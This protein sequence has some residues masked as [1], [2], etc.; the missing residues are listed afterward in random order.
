MPTAKKQDVTEDPPELKSGSEMPI[1]GS[2]INTN[3]YIDAASDIAISTM[4]VFLK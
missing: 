4:S 2:T 1:T 3:P